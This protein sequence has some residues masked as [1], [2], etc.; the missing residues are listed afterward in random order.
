MPYLHD[1]NS[2]VYGLALTQANVTT[3]TTGGVLDMVTGDG[4][5]NLLL[6]T[7]AAN[8]TYFVA[9]VL[10]SASSTGGFTAITGAT[11]AAT[12]SGVTALTF[13][14]DSRYLAVKF[15]FAGTGQTGVNGF[16]V[17]QKKL[18]NG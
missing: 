11:I 6:G 2:S 3:T 17:E 14:R 1:I 5:C 10:Q 15:D 13:L 7:N 16:V 12:T 8:Y 4:N 9:N 18:S